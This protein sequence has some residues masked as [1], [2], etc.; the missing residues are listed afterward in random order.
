MYTSVTYL[1]AGNF[2]RKVDIYDVHIDTHFSLPSLHV[3]EQDCSWCAT[4]GTYIIL[5]SRRIYEALACGNAIVIKPS[6]ITPLSAIRVGELIQAAGFPPGVLN[7]VTGYGPTVGDAIARHPRIDKV[8][9]TGSVV[10]GRR[11]MQAAGATNLKKVTLELGGKSANIVFDDADL[12]QAV[13]WTS[14]ALL[15]VLFSTNPLMRN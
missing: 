10:T 15:C 5:N 11:V 7:I 13:K 6:E 14:A 4:S 1:D 8:T 3:C 12:D 2:P 9:F